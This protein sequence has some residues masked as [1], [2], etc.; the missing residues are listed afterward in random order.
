MLM[1][2]FSIAILKPG[3]QLQGY[4]VTEVEKVITWKFRFNFH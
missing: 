2:Y 1:F 4:R 3:D